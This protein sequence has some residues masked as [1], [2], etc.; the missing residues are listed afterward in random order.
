RNGVGS[1]IH[2]P[3]ALPFTPAFAY[4]KHSAADFPVAAQLAREVLSLPVFP[5]LSDNEAE[6]IVRV[7]RGFA[8]HQS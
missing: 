1:H 6:E 8:V 3:V 2:Y 4:L 7:I 5:E